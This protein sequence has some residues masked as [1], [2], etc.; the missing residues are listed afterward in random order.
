MRV[1]SII[2]ALSLAACTTGAD[3]QKAFIE[4]EEGLRDRMCA[5]R[6]ADCTQKVFREFRSL[7]PPETGGAE[8]TA[9]TQKQMHDAI[10]EMYRCKHER[11]GVK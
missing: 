3:P 2:A 5:C 10:I 4:R 7:P 8:L 9:D 1:F 6:D 11:E